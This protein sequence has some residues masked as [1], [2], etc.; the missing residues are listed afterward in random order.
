[1]KLNNTT[2]SKVVIAE[3]KAFCFDKTAST[4]AGDKKLK[5]KYSVQA[6]DS[7]AADRL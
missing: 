3:S 5:F 2:G 6:G 4:T 7:I 1:M